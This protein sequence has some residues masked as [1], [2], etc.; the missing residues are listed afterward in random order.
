MQS[1]E[2]L[3]NSGGS[4]VNKPFFPRLLKL[5]ELPLTISKYSKSFASSA[6]VNRLQDIPL[7]WNNE[8]TSMNRLERRKHLDD[9]CKGCERYGH[10]INKNG[11]Y[12]VASFL[13]TSQHE[14]AS[15]RGIMCLLPNNSLPGNTLAQ[16]YT[17]RLI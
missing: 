9:F 2:R 14:L 6:K 17:S 7:D 13:S 12:F 3:Q 8:D 16:L 11:Q 10:N 5:D 4:P 1:L 15:K